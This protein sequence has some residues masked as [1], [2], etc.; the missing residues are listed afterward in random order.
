VVPRARGAGAGVRENFEDKA[1]R[2][3]TEG[4]VR[5]RILNEES[6]VATAEVRGNG[7]VYAVDHDDKGWACDCPARTECAHVA[8]LKCVTVLTPRELR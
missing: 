4:R 2:Y 7:A 8:A 6:G 3:L 5:I 1:R